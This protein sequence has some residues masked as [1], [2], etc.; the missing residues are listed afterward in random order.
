MSEEKRYSIGQMPSGGFYLYPAEREDEW[1]ECVY[2]EI[3]EEWAVYI[4]NH[5]EGQV[6][7][8][9]PLENGKAVEDL[10]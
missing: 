9:S 4:G 1:R 7:F 10:G 6:T 8:T 2:H 5:L 3:A